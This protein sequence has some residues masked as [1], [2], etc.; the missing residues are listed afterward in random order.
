MFFLSIPTA[1]YKFIYN[2]F[3]NLIIKLDLSFEKTAIFTVF[4]G[5][6]HFVHT[7]IFDY[8]VILHFLCLAFPIKNTVCLLCFIS[9]YQFIN[10]ITVT[11]DLHYAKF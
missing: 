8:L 4:V 10:I 2:Y 6:L 11:K 1:S 7:F 9:A 3:L 5:V